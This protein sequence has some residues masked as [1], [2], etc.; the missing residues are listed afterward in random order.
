MCYVHHERLYQWIE[1]QTEKIRFQLRRIN[2]N[3][4]AHI[5]IEI[6]VKIV[7]WFLYNSCDANKVTSVPYI[8]TNQI[9]NGDDNELINILKS[10]EGLRELVQSGDAFILI[11]KIS[12]TA[13]TA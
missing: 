9:L 3:V 10:N 11:K 2:W 12:D 1:K 4:D 8:R 6:L 5:R 13:K 7:S